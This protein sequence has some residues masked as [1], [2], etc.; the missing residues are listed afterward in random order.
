MLE[1]EG[2]SI[3]VIILDLILAPGSGFDLVP[4]IRQHCPSAQVMVVSAYLDA[5]A[6][7][8]AQKLGL[9]VLSKDNS[10]RRLRDA[11]GLVARRDDYGVR[12]MFPK[13][14][15]RQVETVEQAMVDDD[16]GAIAAAMR[17][18]RGTV[19]KH[20]DRIREKTGLPRRR[21]LRMLIRRLAIRRLARRATP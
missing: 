11:L 3:D 4:K 13:L 6:M 7:L 1:T 12:V 14:S 2:K 10:V 21:L 20:W 19:R 5:E 15:D 16:D 8:E 9:L 17:I 18:Q